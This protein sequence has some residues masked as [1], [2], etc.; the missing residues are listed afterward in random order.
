ME[1]KEVINM[2]PQEAAKE[3]TNTVP[4]AVVINTVHQE[5][6]EAT[7]MVHQEEDISMD[8]LGEATRSMAHQEVKEVMAS[9]P[10]WRVQSLMQL[11]CNP[12][13]VIQN[14]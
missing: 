13:L 7:S 14:Y 12:A 9:T 4:Q 10:K 8:H 6:K 11:E 2:G 5:E 1:A 3:A